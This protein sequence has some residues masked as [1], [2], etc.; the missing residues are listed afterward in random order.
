VLID[1]VEFQTQAAM[2]I[3]RSIGELAR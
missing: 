1:D 3:A 2:S